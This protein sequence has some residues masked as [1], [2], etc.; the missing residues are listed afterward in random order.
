MLIA[1]AAG[2]LLLGACSPSTYETT[3]PEPAYVRVASYDG[4]YV[5]YPVNPQ[6][7]QELVYWYDSLRTPLTVVGEVPPAPIVT[8][9]PG[10]VVLDSDNFSAK[11]YSNRTEIKRKDKFGKWVTT[12]RP[13]TAA[14]QRLRNH[15]IATRKKR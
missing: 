4:T 9:G 11:L 14:D 10:P 15:I 12:V 7:N 5:P 3:L 2:A 8:K 13:T 6:S 1:G